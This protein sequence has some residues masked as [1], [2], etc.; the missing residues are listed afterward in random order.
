M[1]KS[2]YNGWTNRA[3]WLVS[4]WG[5]PESRDDV[6]MLRDML[7]EQYDELPDGILKDMLDLSEIN[8]DE[9]LAYFDDEDEEQDDEETEEA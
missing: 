2:D 6:E 5:N 8:W 3:T 7:Q 4:V 9:L 1:T